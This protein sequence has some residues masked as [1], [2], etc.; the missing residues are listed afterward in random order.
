MSDTLAVGVVRLRVVADRA[1]GFMAP[2]VLPAAATLEPTTAG[3]ATSASA[4]GT[5]MGSMGSRMGAAEGMGSCS[6]PVEL[7]ECLGLETRGNGRW[8]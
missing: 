4:A 6:R 5:S 2:R 7:A 3:A 1:L 8:W